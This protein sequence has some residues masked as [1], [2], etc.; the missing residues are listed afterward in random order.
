MSL[1]RL[2]APAITIVIALAACLS[3]ASHGQSG[4]GGYDGG[5]NVGASYGSRG[6]PSYPAYPAQ[7]KGAQQKGAQPQQQDSG[8][9]A[10]WFARFDQIRRQA[11][12]TPSERQQAD[13]LL[14]RGMSAILPGPEKIAARNMLTSLTAKYNT[15]TNQLKQLPMINE[16]KELHRGYYQYFNNARMLFSDYLRVQDNL[17]VAD[18]QTGQ[19]LA[20]Q[21]MQRKE[22]L[23]EL[24]S[25]IK[26][27]DKRLR[28]QLDVADYKY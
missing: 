17:F 5:Q 11:Q 19:P 12:M 10:Q 28:D 4:Y 25:Q 18:P 13:K 7:Q 23:E 1:S 20:G 22:A 9:P 8:R 21:L 15:A 16:T 14:S 2:S 24:N 26:S 3:P 6:Y 27:L